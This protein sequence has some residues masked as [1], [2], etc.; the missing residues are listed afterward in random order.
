MLHGVVEKYQF[1]FLCVLDIGIKVLHAFV[2]S[3]SQKLQF[4]DSFVVSWTELNDCAL[5]VLFI[6]SQ[7]ICKQEMLVSSELVID[8]RFHSEAFD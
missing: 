6:R 4:A 1:Q 2:C 5:F 8:L 7:E 3:L